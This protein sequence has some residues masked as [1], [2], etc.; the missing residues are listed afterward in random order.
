MAQANYEIRR[1]CPICGSVFQ[2]RAIDAVYCSKQCSDVAYMEKPR[3]F[4]PRGQVSLTL[5]DK[6][7]L[8]LCGQIRMTPENFA[9]SGGGAL[10]L[11]IV[12]TDG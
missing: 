11:G 1:K 4:D 5:R 3:A 8:T 10:V 6:I 9:F 2:I 12:L 7:R